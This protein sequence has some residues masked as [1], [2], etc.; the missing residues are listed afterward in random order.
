MAR[1]VREELDPNNGQTR[2]ESAKF[3]AR[4]QRFS[5]YFAGA[6]HQ[7][8][9]A[10]PRLSVSKQFHFS[11]N[12]RHQQLRLFGLVTAQPFDQVFGCKAVAWRAPRHHGDQT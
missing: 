10:V 3:N 4:V 12:R 6:H 2:L 9:K 11:V 1:K 7:P 8:Q 5:F